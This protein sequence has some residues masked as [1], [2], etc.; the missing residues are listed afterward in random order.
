[1][2]DGAIVRVKPDRDWMHDGLRVVVLLLPE[3]IG[4]R[5]PRQGREVRFH[6]LDLLIS[7]F[8]PAPRLFGIPFFWTPEFTLT[9]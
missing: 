4:T 2:S 8:Q 1:L 5:L 6:D 9:G 7:I 3:E